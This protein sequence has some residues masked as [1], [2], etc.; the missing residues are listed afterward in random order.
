MPRRR[1]G[2]SRKESA[3]KPAREGCEKC[4]EPTLRERMKTPFFSI[5]LCSILMMQIAFAQNAPIAQAPGHPAA[6]GQTAATSAP[7]PLPTPAITGP[8]K[9]AP[10]NTFDAGPFKKV[11]VNGI[12][13]GM[14]LWQGNHVVG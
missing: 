11:A 1:R 8:L 9:A 14:G 4:K 6:A 10:P 7:T 12:L 2:L 5:L 3:A 13:T